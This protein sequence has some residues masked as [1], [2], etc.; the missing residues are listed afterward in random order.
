M[1][2]FIHTTQRYMY[3]H[4]HTRAR[5][6]LKIA[7]FIWT[8]AK[9]FINLYVWDRVTQFF[10]EREIWQFWRNNCIFSKPFSFSCWG[11]IMFQRER[12]RGMSFRIRLNREFI[13]ILSHLKRF[14]IVFLQLFWSSTWEYSER[15]VDDFHHISVG[16][17]RWHSPKH[18]LWEDH[19]HC[20]GLYGK[21]CTIKLQFD[22]HSDKGFKVWKLWYF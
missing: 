7:S 14:L 16:G 12:E 22:F 3:T 21:M 10:Y 2:N 9:D 13:F 20:G 5:A 11:N 18:V 8:S 15:H 1:I 17:L 4:T 6:R 19:R